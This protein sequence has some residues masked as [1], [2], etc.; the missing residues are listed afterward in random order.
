MAAAEVE[1]VEGL[2]DR[3]NRIYRIE[4][5]EAFDVGD[6]NRRA[7]L[8]KIRLNQSPLRFACRDDPVAQPLFVYDM[9]RRLICAL[10]ACVSAFCAAGVLRLTVEWDDGGRIAGQ[11]AAAVASFAS[12]VALS[13]LFLWIKGAPFAGL[14]RREKAIH[15]L[16]MAF[17][18]AAGAYPLWRSMDFKLYVDHS[19]DAT[20]GPI[21]HWGFPLPV[22]CTAPGYSIATSI[23]LFK[24]YCLTFNFYFW[25]LGIH[26]CCRGIAR[27]AKWTR[28]R[29]CAKVCEIAVPQ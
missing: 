11:T 10:A 3:I 21:T 23:S 5:E 17:A 26:A 16:L 15:V 8:A 9:R 18:T 27:L 1:E 24:V 12:V 28:S 25:V 29:P 7:M 19:E 14:T 13:W 20:V 6:F 4:L 2:L 22:K